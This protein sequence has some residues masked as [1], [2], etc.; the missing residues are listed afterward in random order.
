MFP[1]GRNEYPVEYLRVCVRE[2]RRENGDVA[3]TS[4]CMT[5]TMLEPLPPPATR[6]LGPKRQCH[7]G[8]TFNCSGLGMQGLRTRLTC[9]PCTRPAIPAQSFPS[10]KRESAMSINV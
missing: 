4:L 9:M 5:S 6:A 10:L 1:P 3:R 8:P 7:F 2:K